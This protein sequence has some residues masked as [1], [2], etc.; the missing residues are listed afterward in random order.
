[1]LLNS[2]KE[3]SPTIGDRCYIGAGAKIIG[4][5]YVQSNCRIGANTIVTQDIPENTT[6]VSQNKVRIITHSEQ[7]DNRFWRQKNGVIEYYENGDFR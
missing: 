1:M 5:C 7:M 6:V 3:G 2:E 4:K